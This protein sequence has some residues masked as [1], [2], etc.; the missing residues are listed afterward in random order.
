MK[1]VLA[2]KKT[3][4][5]ARRKERKYAATSKTPSSTS[6]GDAKMTLPTNP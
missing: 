4:K 3:G 6:S 5:P 2:T 1:T